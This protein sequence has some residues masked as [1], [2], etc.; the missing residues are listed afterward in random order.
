MSGKKLRIQQLHFSRIFLQE[1]REQTVIW[2]LLGNQQGSRK[3]SIPEGYFGIEYI[4]NVIN[5]LPL[6]G[7]VWCRGNSNGKGN[8]CAPMTRSNWGLFILCMGE[9]KVILLLF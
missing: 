4:C 1:F 6:V 9:D 8:Y 2:L 3:G 5:D 7:L